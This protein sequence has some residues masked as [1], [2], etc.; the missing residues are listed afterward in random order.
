MQ[1]LKAVLDE[2]HAKNKGVSEEEIVK[3]VTQA[4]AEFRREEY[5]PKE[6]A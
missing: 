5:T 1:E 6:E 3:Y 2:V 4:I